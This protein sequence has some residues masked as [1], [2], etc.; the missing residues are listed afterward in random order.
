MN[1]T[2]KDLDNLKSIPGFPI[3]NDED[4][5]AL[6][7]S[8]HYTAC[9]N[10]FITEFIKQ[11]GT[12]Y[13]AKSDKY[14][15]K[16]FATDV[17]E[18]K[19]D[20]IY[21]AHSYPTKVPP[22]AIVRYL[23]HYTKP[24]DVIYDGFCGTGMTGVAAQICQKPETEFKKIIEKEMPGIKWGA[25]HAILCD[26]SP[27]ATFIAYN[28]NKDMDKKS[29][30]AEANQILE[31]V[32]Q[33]CGWMYQTQHTVDGQIQYDTEG[34]KKPILGKINYTVWSDVFVCPN[35][36]EELI[37]WD[38]AVKDNEILDKFPCT[39]CKTK[40]NKAELENVV[41]TKFDDSLNKNIKQKKQVPVMINYI[42]T[43]GRKSTRY[44][45]KPD[46]FDLDLIKQIEN[47]KIQDWYPNNPMM[48]KGERWGDTWRAGV[49]A[50][51]THVHHFYTKRNLLFLAHMIQKIFDIKNKSIQKNML[52]LKTS[53][54]PSFVSKLT[55]Y[56]FGKRG[57][58]P[59]S[60]TLYVPSFQ[61]ERK[62][63][64]VF[65]NKLK[66]FLF[67]INGKFE[68]V[69]STQSSTK[70]PQT[71]NNSVDYI[72]TDPP[73]GENLMYSELN[74]IQE[75]WL[76]VITNNTQEA[77][78]NDTQK[79]GLAE[80]QKLMAYC[81]SE[82]HRIL[83]PGRWMT[84]VFHNS[85]NSVWIAIQEAL[86]K[87]GFVIADVR[88]LDK[89]QGTIKQK[90]SSSAVKQD[91]VISAY[92]PFGGL[93]QYFESLQSGTEEG[94]WK[95]IDYHLKQLPIIVEL[96]EIVEI[97]AERQKFLLFDRM[98]AFHIQKGLRVPMSAA[99]FYEKLHQKYPERDDM[100]FLP[101]QV[102]QY[103]QIKK[104]TK[105]IQQTTLFVEDEK[106][107]ILWLNEHLKTP[108]TYQQI[109][110]KFLREIHQ[111]KFEKLPELSEILQQNFLQ[112]EK[113]KWYIP[114]PT[115]QKDLE[116]IRIRSLLK[117][118][119]IYKTTKGK[120]KSFRTEAIRAGFEDSWSKEKYDVIVEMG[121]KIPENILQEDITLLMYFDN[122]SSRLG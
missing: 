37:F 5:I 16:P 105:S 7:D 74:F 1:F 53:F 43:K 94:V 18:G 112:D 72:F 65:K 30:E 47:T 32:E 56:N 60:G 122:A 40:L 109:Q 98:V 9:P 71:P 102:I 19:N 83:K 118:F 49:H 89:Q 63:S 44:V 82:N 12:I 62:G 117:E 29:F 48:N 115:Q 17:S 107:S 106:S 20:P 3:G 4:I 25:R 85:Q 73:F 121:N 120:L 116:K 6:S 41:I 28:L 27:I 58:S 51:V 69:I 103:D 80:Y 110:P 95:F 14:D 35:C 76:K 46:K 11:H 15:V 34:T 45:K 39:N 24:G 57:N 61:V 21:N 88:T 84:V 33:E 114:D 55:R 68:N 79:K 97:V 86:E 38:I 42:V 93:E 99:E 8:P 113:G 36:T 108:Q 10:P 67:P 54:D 22:K 64:E 91:L 77:I 111:S 66:D 78:I 81:F 90:P 92:K 26:L 2:K 59:L 75:S 104:T 52:L 23:L 101:D 119:E 13:D 31:Q 87:A 96:K 100:Y 70:I 50:G